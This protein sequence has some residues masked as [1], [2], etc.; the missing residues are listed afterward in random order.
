MALLQGLN[1]GGTVVHKP[2][3]TDD[4]YLQL[5][6]QFP[7]PV[8]YETLIKIHKQLY[9]GNREDSASTFQQ[10]QQAYQQIKD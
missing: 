9:F 10:C 2:S 8:P 1:D 7:Q 6:Q 4:E 5:I 3:R